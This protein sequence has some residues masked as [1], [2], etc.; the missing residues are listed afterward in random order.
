MLTLNTE[1][2]TN[3]FNV[4][5]VIYGSDTKVVLDIFNIIQGS[6]NLEIQ[7]NDYVQA[8]ST[9]VCTLSDISVTG[10][11]FS[12]NDTIYIVDNITDIGTDSIVVPSWTATVFEYDENNDELHIGNVKSYNQDS[13]GNTSTDLSLLT[14]AGNSIAKFTNISNTPTFTATVDSYNSTDYE[15]YGRVIRKELVGNMGRIWL[16]NFNSE[17]FTTNL[18][19]TSNYGWLAGVENVDNSITRINKYFRGFDNEKTIFDL[20][21]EGISYTP[22]DPGSPLLIFVNSILQSEGVTKDYTLFT[23][24][25]KFNA[26]PPNGSSFIGYYIGKLRILDDI[27]HLFDSIETGFN[28]RYNNDNYSLSLSDNS[29]FSYE[30]NIIISLNSIIQVPEISYKIIGSRIIFSEPPRIGS[31]FTALSYI[32]SNADIISEI[33]LN[34]IESRDIIKL[35]NESNRIV[36]IIQSSNSL[37]SFEYTGSVNGIDAELTANILRGAIV[38]SSITRSGSG[39]KSKPKVNIIS[40]TGSDGAIEAIIGIPEIIVSNSGSG[41]SKATVAVETTVDDDFTNPIGARY[42]NAIISPP[43]APKGLTGNVI[44][45]GVVSLNWDNPNDFTI[46]NY[47]ISINSG[48]NFSTISNSHANTISYVVFEL[49]PNTTYTIGLRAVNHTGTGEISIVTVQV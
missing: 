23:D 12:K 8:V 10:L 48:L 24:K 18:T 1:L 34:P 32:G 4:D 2:V 21:S 39:Y 47:E 6:N 17:D 16:D 30:N 11:P 35:D 36:D 19:I 9:I 46:I 49:T 45:M 25:I 22:V 37:H 5:D 29:T 43:E 31:N 44:S 7:I 20:S 38:E 3:D 33:T 41:Y 42:N 15:S 14:V 13:G 27:S 40:P 28:L 26:P